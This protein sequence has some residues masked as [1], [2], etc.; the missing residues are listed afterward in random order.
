MPVL[1]AEVGTQTDVHGHEG[2]YTGAENITPVDQATQARYY[3]DLLEL[4][5]CDTSVEALLLFR[6]IDIQELSSFQSG[7]F[8]ADFTPK[9]SAEAIRAKIASARGACQTTQS[10]WV[11]TEQVVGAAAAFGDLSRPKWIRQRAWNFS[12]TAKEDATYEAHILT[13]STKRVVLSAK[14]AIKAYYRPLVQFPRQ[15]LPEGSYVYTITM[16]SLVNPARRSSFTSDPFTVGPAGGGTN[17]KLP[18]PGKTNVVPTGTVLVRL[19]GTTTFVALKSLRTLPVGTEVDVH[20][21]SVKLT[22]SDGASGQFFGGTF[23]IHRGTL[24]KPLSRS[25]KPPR[26]I[27]VTSLWLSH[28]NFAVCRKHRGEAA[29]P[30]VV[31]SLWGRGKGRFR[32][33]GRFASA[34]VRGTYWLVQ[35]RCDGTF[36]R[37][38]QGVVDV[39]DFAKRKHVLV[40]AGKTYLARAK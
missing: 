35:D 23:T 33:K 30:V 18:P 13:A 12:A 4:A 25:L 9:Q 26:R 15:G 22:A 28:E 7:E 16:R 17:V 36:V 38:R 8:F 27:F 3:V 6:L 11:H 5:A 29:R 39:F 40:R 14:G 32:T 34:A 1:L 37:V 24:S 20:R 2:A 31:G 21:G 10:A 19:P